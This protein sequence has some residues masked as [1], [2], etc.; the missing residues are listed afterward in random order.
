MRCFR[1][2]DITRFSAVSTLST[3]TADVTHRAHAII[4]TVFSDLIDGPL[5]HRP[6]GSFG[7]NSAWVL[8]AAIAHN[9][10]RAFGT[11][12]SGTVTK[13]RGVTLRRKIVNIP[14]RFV[15]P[16][17]HTDA[18]PPAEMAVAR[19]VAS[20]VSQHHRFQATRTRVT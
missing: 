5:A 2:G 7:A 3:T 8:C 19:C 10:L 1:C 18:A 11:V 13:V 14:A 12:A 6:S 4:E 16:W 17:A 20:V 9:L 15:R